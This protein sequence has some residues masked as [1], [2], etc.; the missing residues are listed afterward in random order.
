MLM[1]AVSAEENMT[2]DDDAITSDYMELDSNQSY[3]VSDDSI[4][5][6]TDIDDDKNVSEEADSS[7]DPRET[8]YNNVKPGFDVISKASSA[9]AGASSSNDF[10]FHKSSSYPKYTSADT[11]TERSTYEKLSNCQ[12]PDTMGLE[13]LN[14]ISCKDLSWPTVS[15]YSEYFDYF[16]LDCLKNMIDESEIEDVLNANADIIDLKTIDCLKDNLIGF[17]DAGAKYVDFLALN[18][19][20]GTSPLTKYEGTTVHPDSNGMN[21][22]AKTIYQ[23]LGSWL[24]E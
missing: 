22:M 3:D 10:A 1:S 5:E 14:D 2:I 9:I 18:G 13:A 7:Q 12:S 6:D 20:K 4:T 19:F 15:S 23:Q 16:K 17:M 8:Q 24:D 11:S 21:F